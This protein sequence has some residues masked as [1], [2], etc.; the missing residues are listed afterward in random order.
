[1]HF[2]Q[3]KWRIHGGMEYL[4]FFVNEIEMLMERKMKQYRKLLLLWYLVI[5]IKTENFN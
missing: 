1:M 4:D 5:A 2:A 3:H